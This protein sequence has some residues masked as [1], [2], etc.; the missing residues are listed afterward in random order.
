MKPELSIF[1]IIARTMNIAGIGNLLKQKK[2]GGKILLGNP[3]D[4]R[5]GINGTRLFLLAS[6][7]TFAYGLGVGL[8]TNTPI[9]SFKLIFGLG[10]FA[11]R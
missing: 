11:T 10:D 6:D 5:L 3:N 1:D 9:E 8:R 4:F 2:L 7:T